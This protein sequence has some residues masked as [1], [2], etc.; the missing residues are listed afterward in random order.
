MRK[1]E[2]LDFLHKKLLAFK[3]NKRRGYKKLLT[4]KVIKKLFLPFMQKQK[5]F[6][7]FMQKTKKPGNRNKSYCMSDKTV[8]R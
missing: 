2:L 4:N 3:K 6:L 8:I 1:R 7:A 5:N